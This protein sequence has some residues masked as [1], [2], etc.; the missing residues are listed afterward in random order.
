MSR[1]TQEFR[2]YLF[3]FA[4][5][6]FTSYGQT[7]QSIQ[8]AVP[9]FMQNPTTPKYMYF[10]LGWSAFARRYLRNRSYFLFL[11][12]LRWFSSLR[13]PYVPMYSVH[14]TVL[15]GGFPHSDTSG[16]TLV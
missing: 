3:A 4:Y 12:L 7:F 8:L 10:G 13:S 1:G 5:R 15:D 11:E 6:T 14:N 9:Y 16:S 2:R